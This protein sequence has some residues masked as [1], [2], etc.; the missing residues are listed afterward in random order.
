MHMCTHIAEC[1]HIHGSICSSHALLCSSLIPFSQ[2]SLLSL[3]AAVQF[4]VLEAL[5][6]PLALLSS[7]LEGN[8]FQLYLVLERFPC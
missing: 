4:L 7:S 8:Y 3:Q 1:V 6:M 2:L 5:M